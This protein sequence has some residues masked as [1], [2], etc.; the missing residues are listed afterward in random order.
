MFYLFS[1]YQTPYEMFIQQFWH[2]KSKVDVFSIGL[3]FAEISV[4]MNAEERNQ[5]F[6]CYRTGKAP[7][8]L[9][10]EPVVAEFVL[11]LTMVDPDERPT[12]RQVLD[13]PFLSQTSYKE[14]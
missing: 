4:A 6:N 8:I 7:E 9:Q 2:Y 14:C 3:I 13:S 1:K 11:W 10:N 5:I 12:C